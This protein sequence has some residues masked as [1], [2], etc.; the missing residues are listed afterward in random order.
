MET[1]NIVNLIE[2]NPITKLSSDYNY[3]LLVKIKDNFTDFEQHVFLSSFYC[4]LKY[5]PINDF[6]IDLDDVWK[7]IGFSQKVKAKQLLE[8][9]FT[10]NKDYTVSLYQQVKH[11]THTKGGQNK[12]IIMLNINTFK[13]FCLKAGTKKAEDIHE[14]Y[15]KMEEIIQQVIEEDCIELKKQLEDQKQNIE[16]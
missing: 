7:W 15:I 3:K 5:H 16:K 13:K 12:E 6:V 8:K 1:L 11:S 10:M 4:Y 14:Y 2:S 9:H